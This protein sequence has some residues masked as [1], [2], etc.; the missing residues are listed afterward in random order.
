M[1]KLFSLSLEKNQSGKAFRLGLYLSSMSILLGG[2]III[3]IQDLPLLAGVVVVFIIILVGNLKF[4]RLNRGSKIHTA[5]FFGQFIPLASAVTIMLMIAD[6][7]P[8]DDPLSV[9]GIIIPILI[10]VVYFLVLLISTWVGIGL[11]SK[12]DKREGGEFDG[13]RRGW[14][15]L[16][17][18][19][20]VVFLLLS[21]LVMLYFF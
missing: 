18:V 17:I 13:A 5:W 12:F 4:S 10:A 2:G 14:P 9:L 3:F 8:S 19:F 15:W 7:E 21:L 20:S 16:N 11:R 1:K 6:S